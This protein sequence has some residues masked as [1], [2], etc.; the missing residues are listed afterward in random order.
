MKEVFVRSKGN[1]AIFESDVPFAA[2]SVSTNPGEWPVISETNRVALLQLSFAD[3][4]MVKD[5]TPET[6]AKYDLFRPDQAKQILDFVTENWDKVD[7]FLIHCEAG[8]SR[9]PAIA[10]AITKIAG[11]EDT[12]YFRHYSPNRYVY[13]TILEAHFGPLVQ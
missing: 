10:A 5:A 3:R 1:A 9:S 13:K 12:Y 2:I 4:D 11:G 8:V 7:A 6:I